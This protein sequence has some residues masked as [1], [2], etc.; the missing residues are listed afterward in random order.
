MVAV[1][2]WDRV[3]WYAVRFGLRLARRAGATR[4]EPSAPGIVAKCSHVELLEVIGDRYFGGM[5]ELSYNYRGEVLNNRRIELDIDN[6]YT[7]PVP[8]LRTYRLL[9]FLKPEPRPI[10]WWQT[11]VRTWDHAD[12]GWIR[13]RAHWEPDPVEYPHA[14]YA[15]TGFDRARAESTVRDILDEVGIEHRPDALDTS[16]P[17]DDGHDT[18]T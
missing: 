6:D 16:A 17:P 18:L 4:P 5:D 1:V 10:D 12:A 11:H 8:D 9:P 14:H 3:P 2:E 7:T 15:G 13:I